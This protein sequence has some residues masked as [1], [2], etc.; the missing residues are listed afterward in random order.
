MYGAVRHVGLFEHFEPMCGLALG[1]QLRHP[2]QRG[3]DAIG[4]VLDLP[5]F[6]MAKTGAQPLPLFVGERRDRYP[7][8]AGLEGIETAALR[9]LVQLPDV[10]A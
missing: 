9:H 4:T 6:G 10:G 2:T 3:A 8:V 1:Q 5:P 7:A